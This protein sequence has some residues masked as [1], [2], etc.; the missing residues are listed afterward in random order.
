M[1]HD[2]IDLVPGERRQPLGLHLTAHDLQ[3]LNG[4]G[5]KEFG[6][7]A[8]VL[9]PDDRDLLGPALQ[10]VDPRD[11]GLDEGLP[12]RRSDGASVADGYRNRV[13]RPHTQGSVA[14]RLAATPRAP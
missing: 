3:Y 8:P 10:T 11:I 2:P 14:A 12:W 1:A 5:L 13:P 7:T 9:G 6:E 4:I